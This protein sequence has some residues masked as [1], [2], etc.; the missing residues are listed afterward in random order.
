MGNLAEIAAFG[1]WPALPVTGYW[2][3]Y[4]PLRRGKPRWARL[5]G[6]ASLAVMTAAG[7]ALWSL[8]LLLSAELGVYHAAG[9]G[10]AGWVISLAGGIGYLMIRRR[11]AAETRPAF[12]SWDRV[13]V[14]GLLLAAVI[15]L[16]YPTESIFGGID[17]GVYANTAV[18]LAREGHLE[19]PYP[20]R[21]PEEHFLG[22]LNIAGF[23]R[24]HSG[25]NPQFGHLLPCWLAQAYATFG[26]GGLFR[27]N[28]LLAL[29]SLLCF[30]AVCLSA[31]PKPYAVSAT[32][33]LAL[34]PSQIWLA[35]I[36]LS[37]ILAQLFI[38]AG[39][40]V[41]SQALKTRSAPAARWAGFFL[42][43]AT[44]VR[45]DCFLLGP[46]LFSAHFLFRVV[47][48]RALKTASSLWPALYQTG[49]PTFA[50]SVVIYMSFSREYF[51]GRL[52]PLVT[53]IGI[54]SVV[55]LYPLLAAT[56]SVQR[57]FRRCLASKA[58]LITSGALV[59]AVAGYAYWLRPVGGVSGAFSWIVEQDPH[60]L[61]GN[62]RRNSL[63][64][65]ARYLSP[66]VVWSAIL[67][68]WASLW[69]IL[70]RGRVGIVTTLVVWAGFAILYLYD[71]IIHPAHFW[72]IRRFVPVVIPGFVLFSTIG[73][74]FALRRLSGRRAH[75]AS[76][77]VLAFLLLFTGQASRRILFFADAEGCMSQIRQ[78]A[79]ALPEDEII[80][81]PVTSK[82]WVRWAT[83]LY[84]S[85]GHR[86]VPLNLNSRRGAQGL[87]YWFQ[88]QHDRQEPVYLLYDDID[89]PP[90]DWPEMASAQH[91]VIRFRSFR[92]TV[93]PLP[94]E[95]D[96]YERRVTLYRTETRVDTPRRPNPN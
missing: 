83:P 81:L 90:N 22:F 59:F 15:Y 37:E 54:A 51:T 12:S 24:T 71:P 27:F 18:F 8:P 6:V 95:I 56:P 72:A 65:L 3:F 46:L 68:A 2:T 5:P 43:L 9:L 17:Q 28:G 73:L 91:F 70:R 20:W 89:P 93:E 77:A 52:L 50:A 87:H 11:D 35:R 40:L 38:W 49:V 78:L 13:L 33:F 84:L 57:S 79:A 26:D 76:A 21:D 55:T 63:I 30:H 47:A 75:L 36:T 48:P 7:I 61:L 41:M 4:R 92:S 42:G 58:L 85:F 31:V 67:G 39:L 80:L 69:T 32:L 23:Y 60:S 64:N 82:E 53:M 94:R 29:V 45:I 86:I 96:T 74:R 25:M 16:G 34:N 88:R 66:L 14:A 44:L 10:I 19:V 62:H 1:I